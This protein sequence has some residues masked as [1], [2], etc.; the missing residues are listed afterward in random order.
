MANLLAHGLAA[1]ATCAILGSIFGLPGITWGIF[2]AGFLAMLAEMD[3]DELSPNKRSPFGHSILFGFLWTLGISVIV[4]GMVSG[5]ILSRVNALKLTLAV[6]SGYISHIG[7]DSFTKEGIYTFPK[8]P[9][10]KKWVT[11][12]SH[13]DRK[14]WEYWHLFKN[15]K[16]EKLLRANDDPILNAFVS[17]PSLLV[18]IIFV[19]IMPMP[20]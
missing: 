12:L 17:I 10:F 7:I 5:D 1:M 2:L 8:G 13:G 20:V 3:L 18:I 4:W 15:A 16:F 19:V 9:E 14:C 6:I 11:R